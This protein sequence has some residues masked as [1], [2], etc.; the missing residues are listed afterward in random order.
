VAEASE[1]ELHFTEPPEGL[2]TTPENRVLAL[3]D[4]P[5][6]VAAA[7]DDLVQ[8]G[9][10]RN[11]IWVLCGPE[12]AERLDVTGRHHGLKGRIY[13]IVEWIGDERELLLETAEHL[14]SGGLAVTV[15]ADDAAAGNAARILHQHGGHGMAH[16]GKAHFEPL[17]P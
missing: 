12:G 13:R 6:A 17:G 9:F 3:M 4:D 1:E 16:F 2:L 10:D 11:S 7:I 8:A 15:P 14:S 5:Q